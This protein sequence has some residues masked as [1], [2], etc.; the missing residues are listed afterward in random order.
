MFALDGAGA[1]LAALAAAVPSRV[2]SSWRVAT[3]L[4]VALLVAATAFAA[5]GVVFGLFC[6]R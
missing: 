1:V 3:G 2:S 4:T 5:H 6:A